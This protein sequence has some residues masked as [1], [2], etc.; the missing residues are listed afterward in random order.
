MTRS[1]NFSKL[2]SKPELIKSI[3]YCQNCFTFAPVLRIPSSLLLECGKAAK[4]CRS[5]GTCEKC[6][7]L[8]LIAQRAKKDEVKSDKKPSRMSINDSSTETIETD[9]DWKKSSTQQSNKSLCDKC[10]LEEFIADGCESCGNCKFCRAFKKPSESDR[11]K[12]SSK[13]NKS[14]S[15][16]PAINSCGDQ[17]NSYEHMKEVIEHQNDVILKIQDE[18][19]YS[20]QRH[21]SD[22]EI[23]KLAS[24]LDDAKSKLRRMVQLV[25]IEQRRRRDEAWKPIKVSLID[26]L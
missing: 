17:T 14:N 16:V 13:K 18:I 19:Q 8:A 6:H 2:S 9:V 10:Q 26:D 23:K 12:K 5:I 11:N 25:I 24:D 4:S 21:A 3:A 15:K 22:Y 1:S 7:Q 20:V